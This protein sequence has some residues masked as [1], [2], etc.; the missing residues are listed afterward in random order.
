MVVPMAL[1]PPIVLAWIWFNLP[2]LRDDPSAGAIFGKEHLS[3]DVL[4]LSVGCLLATYGTRLIHSL[5]KEAFE[6]RRIQQYTL[7]GRIASGGMGSTQ[8]MLSVVDRGADAVAMADVLHYDRLSIDD[9]RTAA[10]DARLNVRH[11]ER[12]AA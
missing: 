11:V 9:V 10:L 3:D 6:A 8:D 4:M 12:A 7:K 5:R 2:E 1:G